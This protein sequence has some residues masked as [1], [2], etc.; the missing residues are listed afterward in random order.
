[1]CWSASCRICT[2]DLKGTI[3]HSLTVRMVQVTVVKIIDVIAV[4]NRL[5]SAAWAMNMTVV[6]VV[7]VIV[8]AHREVLSLMLVSSLIKNV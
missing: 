1:M 7:G 8:V 6:R 5:V 2:A 3:M 4:A